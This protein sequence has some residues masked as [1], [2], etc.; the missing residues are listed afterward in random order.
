MMRLKSEFF[1]RGLLRGCV[2]LGRIAEQQ[3]F[4]GCSL[5]LNLTEEENTKA[6]CLNENFSHLA[7]IL[8]T[9]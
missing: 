7:L 5:Q 3:R 2:Q 8:F 9:N 6:S 4:Q 1:L